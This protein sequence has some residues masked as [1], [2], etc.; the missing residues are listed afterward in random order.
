MLKAVTYIIIDRSRPLLYRLIRIKQ[1][2]S[3]SRKICWLGEY[4]I[5]THSQPCLWFLVFFTNN[6]E[7]AQPVT[8][9]KF[10]PDPRI[11]FSRQSTWK[12][13]PVKNDQNKDVCQ[14]DMGL[15]RHLCYDAAS[16]T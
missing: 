9:A 4:S 1:F 14:H 15:F 8:T 10:S 13:P 7:G 11:S 5:F 3:K 6:V 16:K 12:T 2:W